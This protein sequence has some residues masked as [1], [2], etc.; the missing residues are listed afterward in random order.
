MVAARRKTSEAGTRVERAVAVASQEEQTS[1]D[2]NSGPFVAVG[3][4]GQTTAQNASSANGVAISS[5]AQCKIAPLSGESI[6]RSSSH[7]FSARG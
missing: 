1:G 3:S 2:G 4:A 7:V 5:T 6:S